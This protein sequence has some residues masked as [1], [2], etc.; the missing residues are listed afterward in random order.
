MTTALLILASSSLAADRN[1]FFAMDTALRDGKSRSAAEQATLLK[2]LGYD[3]IGTSGYPS[4]ELF[5]AFEKEGLKVFNTY[6]MLTFD[7]AKPSLEPAL[8]ELVPRLKGHGTALWIAITGVTRDGLK[9]KS[10]AP[11]GAR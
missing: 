6:L 1:P 3:G 7:S 5:A 9:L 8:K 11:L 2:E 4:N 10:S